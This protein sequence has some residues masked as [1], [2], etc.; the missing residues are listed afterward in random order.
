MELYR[1]CGLESHYSTQPAVAGP[2]TSL[3]AV[4]YPS[5]HSSRI[6]FGVLFAAAALMAAGCHS[7]NSN[8]GYGIE[9][10]TVTDDPSDFTSYTTSLA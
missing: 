6:T 4:V 5:R 10:V 3:E 9:W 1:A 2:F 7:N 8:S